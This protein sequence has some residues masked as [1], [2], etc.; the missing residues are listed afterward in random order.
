MNDETRAQGPGPAK[1]GSPTSADTAMVGHGAGA[2]LAQH[3]GRPSSYSLTHRELT[4]ELRRCRREG[5][6]SWEIRARFDFGTV[7]YAA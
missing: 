4:A 7:R 6:Q 1:R 5:W 2:V 3:F